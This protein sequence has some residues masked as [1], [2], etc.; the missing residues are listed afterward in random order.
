MAQI[1]VKVRSDKG[2]L[3]VHPRYG[4]LV[5]GTK[6]IIEEEHFAEELFERPKGFQSPLEK[7]D[8][9]RADELQLRVGHQEP[10]EAPPAASTEK[11]EVAANA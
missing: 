7:A 9:E 6:L 10:T 11:K 2:D 3:G 1:T 4:A 5:G 8:K